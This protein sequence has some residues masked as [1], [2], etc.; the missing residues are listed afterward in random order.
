VAVFVDESA[1][2]VVSLQVTRGCDGAGA[3]DPCRRCE[4]ERAVRPVRVVVID[5]DAEHVLE[6]SAVEDQEPV[7]ALSANRADE[8]FGDRVRLRRA[9]RCFDDLD[10]FACEDGI[11]VERVLAVSVAD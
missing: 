2:A 11:E 4:V 9:H 5:E 8:P 6:V 7:E 1:E 10:A 3:A